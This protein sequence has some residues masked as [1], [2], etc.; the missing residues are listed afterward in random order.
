MGSIGDVPVMFRFEEI[1]IGEIL[2]RRHT[3]DGSVM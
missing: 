2:A 3:G 1:M